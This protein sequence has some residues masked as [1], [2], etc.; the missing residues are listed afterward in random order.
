MIF[1]YLWQAV[2]VFVGILGFVLACGALGAAIGFGIRWANGYLSKRSAKV[3][4]AKEYF[5]DLNHEMNLLRAEEQNIFL[6]GAHDRARAERLIRKHERK[7][8]E[9]EKVP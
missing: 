8:S 7:I 3:R 9:L 1:H 2:I 5:H 6:S 4:Q